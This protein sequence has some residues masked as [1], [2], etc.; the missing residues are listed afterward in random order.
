MIR[1]VEDGIVQQIIAD[2]AYLKHRRLEHGDD[3]VVG[4]NR[5]QTQQQ[6]ELTLFS[7]DAESQST[8]LARLRSVRS[9]RDPVAVE[10]AL[11]R[12]RET[13]V[14]DRNC[15]PALIEASEAYCTIG[16]MS[17]VMRSVFGEFREP[18]VV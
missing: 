5:F 8:Q 17:G 10:R 1:C 16:E 9:T 13:L 12:L 7:L 3:V 15:M 6:R 14:S 18:I 11:G 4:V 2:E